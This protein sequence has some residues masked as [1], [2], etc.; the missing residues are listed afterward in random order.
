MARSDLA[1]GLVLAVVG[2]VLAVFVILGES[3]PGDE[4]EI[5]PAFMPAAAALTIALLGALQAVGAL[6]GGAALA[7][8]EGAWPLFLA[9]AGI[10]L[11]AATA[12]VAWVGF[13]AGGALTVVALGL[14]M[15]ARGPARWWLLGVAVALPGLTHALAWHGLRL[16]LP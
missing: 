4:G 16:A 8:E 5:A 3:A 7:A 9:A 15:G 6:R 13:V 11:A 14:A 2:V 10:A 12:L 1:S